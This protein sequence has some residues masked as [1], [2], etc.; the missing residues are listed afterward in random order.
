MSQESSRV[1]WKQWLWIVRTLLVAG[2]VG[3]A[4]LAVGLAAE[5][6]FKDRLPRIKPL[7]PAEQMK[8]FDILPGFKIEMVAAEPL[9]TDPVDL[10]FDED[11]RLWVVE[12]FNYSEDDTLPKHGKIRVLEDTDN[13]GRFDKSTIFVDDLSWNAA[14]ACFDGGVFVTACP[15]LLY[16][17]DTNGDGKAD[18][19]EVVLIGFSQTN[20]NAFVNSLRWR[21]DN[22]FHAISSVSATLEAVKWNAGKG[23]QPVKLGIGSRN[24]SFEPRT[25]EL[26]LESG[27]G[28]HGMGLGVWG[29]SFTTT[30]SYPIYQFMYE[31]RYI[32]RNP[33]YAA[34]GAQ[35]R[36]TGNHLKFYRTC[37]DEPWRLVRSDVRG[38][39]ANSL[40][41]TTGKVSYFTSV[42]G[43]TIYTG[44]A[45]PKEYQGNA[46]LCEGAG[47]LVHRMRLDPDSVGFKAFRT[48]E[49]T[50]FLTSS[51]IWFRPCQMC[52]APDGTLYFVDMYREVFEH[53][54]S[55]PDSIMKHL[56]IDSGNDMGR[57]FRIVPDGFKQPAPVRLGKKTTPE[58][59]ALLAH[60][61]GWHRRTAAR[62]L[63]ERQD[64][65]AIGPLKKLAAESSS[66]L[67][68][69]HAICALEGLK[70]ISAD[71]LLA[72]LADTHP[73]VRRHAIRLSEP[74]LDD[75]PE[76]REK[77]YALTAD[78]SL[79]VRY[80]LAFTLGQ[81][82]DARSVAAL[83]EIAVKDAGDRWVKVAIMSSLAG[84][85]G[86]MVRQL[87][88]KTDCCKTSAGR[89][90]L[91]EI[92]NQTG[93]QRNAE[94]IAVVL[95]LLE[96]L[97]DENKPVAQNVVR[98]LSRGLGRSGS[99]LR[100]ALTVDGYSRAAKLLVEMVETAKTVAADQEASPSSR[101]RAIGSLDLVPY[102]DAEEILAELLEGRQPQVVQMAVIGT[103]GKFRKPEVAQ[104]II[105]AWQ[106]LSPKVQ[107]L[108]TE[109][110]FARQ[111]RIIALL[112]AIEQKTVS[113]SQLDANRIQYLLKHSNKI[114]HAK[115]AELLSAEKLGSR[116]DVVKDY[117]QS[118]AMKSDCAQGKAVFKKECST[119]H[120]LEEVGYDLG[121]PLSDIKKRGR[122]FI[123]TNV[124]DPNREINPTYLN[125]VLI[126]DEGLSVTG[127]ITAESATS[128]T[129]TRAEGE[130][131]TVLRSQIDELQNT[132]VSIMPEGLEKQLSKQNLA[133]LI[134]YLM[135][136]K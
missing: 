29:D 43:T 113:P 74:L 50:E 65:K 115:A 75:S 55:I 73:E 32:A 30:N 53:P 88:A 39:T 98:G 78:E 86:H 94:Q 104:V 117:S 9:T 38:G 71:V 120:K 61:N 26:K 60:P 134:A 135:S 56:D 79:R 31:D 133:D 14:I 108:A 125:Y 49:E 28:Q 119:C 10:A 100:K 107:G 126:T 111:D 57:I 5:K 89:A 44:S 52:N 40:D 82:P 35:L 102:E 85:A 64:A 33:H 36:I 93:R 42:C 124:L 63:F 114:I 16:L 12:L 109:T 96:T 7:S 62:L 23:R 70:A 91:E 132:G 128:I 77:L 15:D 121:L 19:R 41:N 24:I 27:H 37:P 66:P 6:D 58:L 95:E 106:S 8:T 103:L 3:A 110:L 83:A 22:R 130:S 68:R 122:E 67:G 129:L 17:K 2:L 11:G 84:R 136:V 80:Q 123:L 105:E 99:A 20:I 92:T 112:D 59:V 97:P 45:F 51:D 116:N 18:L 118:L 76:L 81:I 127:M 48:E 1:V 131:D 54:R 34:P 21:L 90:F 46:F 47:S 69:M 101:V 13:D 87:A 4:C 72:R 25:G